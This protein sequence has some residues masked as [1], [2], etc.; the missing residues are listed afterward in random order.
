LIRFFFLQFNK[1]TV[2]K[3]PLK[4]LVLKLRSTNLHDRVSTPTAGQV[5]FTAATEDS[6]TT[7]TAG[8]K[9]QTLRRVSA[10]SGFSLIEIIIVL[11]ILGTLIAVLI[12]NLG[13]GAEKAKAKS[14]TVKAG[15]IQQNLLRYQSDVGKLPTTAEGLTSLTTNPGNGKWG[16]PYGTEEDYKDDW[17]NSFEYELSPKGAKLT[18]PGIDGQVGTEDDLVYIGGR[19]QEAA[20]G[21]E[22]TSD[23]PAP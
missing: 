21:A 13:G 10:E 12:G 3:T 5:N 17:G 11:G 16:G 18:S 4:M 8:N 9:P 1:E 6:H 22:G 20:G 15:Q 14:T 23:K 19:L 7:P 2:M